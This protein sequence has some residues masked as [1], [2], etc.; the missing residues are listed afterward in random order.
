MFID[1]HNIS[2][3]QLYR[4]GTTSRDTRWVSKQLILHYVL[5]SNF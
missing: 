3:Q 5:V 1:C 4:N 2:V